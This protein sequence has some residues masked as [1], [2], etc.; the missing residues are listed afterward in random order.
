[1]SR[2]TDYCDLCCDECGQW[3]ETFVTTLRQ[4]RIVMRPQGW[5]VRGKEDLCPKCSENRKRDKETR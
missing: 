1:V 2:M 5:T 4:A 3:A